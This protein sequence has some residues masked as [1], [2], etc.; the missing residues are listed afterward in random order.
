MPGFDY[1]GAFGAIL[2]AD[3]VD[4]SGASSTS[5][6]AQVTADGEL[7]IG[8][9]SSPHIRVNTLTA[10][11]GITITNGPGTIEIAAT[12]TFIWENIGASQQLVANHG[13]F[14]SFG[15]ALSLLLPSNSAVGDIIE[16]VLIGSTSWTITQAAGQR[17]RLANTQT[18]L[19]AGGSI[20]SL[21]QG[22]HLRLVCQTADQ[23]W[24]VAG[25]TGGGYTVV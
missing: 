7:L 9:G 12:P 1:G 13:Y 3:N 18:T 8:A 16:V 23:I 2:F 5:G 15:G 22:D 19:G 21:Q 14:C 20:A 25:N 4:F 11:T 6:T 10:G 17:I 24:V